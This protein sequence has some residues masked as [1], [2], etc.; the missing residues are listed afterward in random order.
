MDGVAHRLS[1][2]RNLKLEY[3]VQQDASMQYN[4]SYT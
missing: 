1:E 4:L 2:V 3:T